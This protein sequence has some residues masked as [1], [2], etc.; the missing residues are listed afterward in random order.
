MESV[1]IIGLGLIGGTLARRLVKNGDAPVVFDLRPEAVDSAVEAGAIGARSSRELA[2]RCDLVF[3]CVQ[4][5]DQCVAAVS[6]DEGLL[7]GAR[8]GTCISVLS[9][10]LPS[11]IVSLAALAADRGVDLVDT[12]V[13]GRGMYSVEEG[14]MS[15]LVGD[16]GELVAR[17]EPTLRRFASRVV[18]AGGLG[19]GAALKLAHN[20]VVYAGFAAMIEAVE[21]A[22]AAGVRDGLVEQVAQASGALSELSAFHLPFYKHLRDEPH[23]A[24]EDEILRVA[25][26]LLDKD[27]TDAVALGETHGVALPV[28]RLLSHS[29]AT[30]F[31]VER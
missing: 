9:T 31:Q 15:V 8:P 19:S 25:A 5:D 11:S 20:I 26:A 16:E 18:P 29:G 6:G 24:D 27:L 17:L 10:V 21:L 22:R 1:G 2:E 4:T 13:T 7:E 3:V 23:A 28:A 12:P 14:T 30:I